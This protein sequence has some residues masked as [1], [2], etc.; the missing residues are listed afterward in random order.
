VTPPEKN[1]KRPTVLIPNPF[2]QTYSGAAIASGADPVYVSCTAETN[3]MPD[4][5]SITEEQF[6]RASCFF[7]C[8]PANPQGTFADEKLLKRCIELARRHDFVLLLDECYAEIYNDEPPMGG[9]EVCAA[10][11]GSM[12]NVVTFHSLS[13]RS[14]APG[15]RSG[16]VAGDPDI[17]S[18]FGSFRDYASA[19]Q[20]M[21]IMAVSTMLWN[22]DEHV[23]LNR[24]LYRKKF[25]LA[26]RILGQKP[27]YYTPPGGFFLWL[28]VGDSVEVTKRLWMEQGVRVLPGAYL[29][30]PTTGSNPGAPY[31]RLALVQDLDSTERALEKVARVI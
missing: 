20:P 10:L 5:D 18:V 3:F 1:G 30:Q 17:L 11:G 16:F 6:E 31:I 7:L 21:P 27:G 25:A 19:V 14:S 15:L 29:T 24:E 26:D 9:L 22:D 8:S 4:I 23:V 12:K 2:Y 28:D 13:K